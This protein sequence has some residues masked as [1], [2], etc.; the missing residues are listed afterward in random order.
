MQN[1]SISCIES[2]H[3]T[4]VGSG[5]N[6]NVLVLTDYRLLLATVA[7]YAQQGAIVR[8]IPLL[9]RCLSRV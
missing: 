5:R 9:K 2:R 3:F 6:K 8:I 4:V 7:D 1:L